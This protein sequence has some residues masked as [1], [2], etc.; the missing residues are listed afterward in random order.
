MQGNKQPLIFC[1]DAWCLYWKDHL[2]TRKSIYLNVLG[3]CESGERI[4]L[5]PE[6][7]ERLRQEQRIWKPEDQPK[8][9]PFPP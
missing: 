7:L 8:T 4:S 5:P 2:C 6:E 1:E 9:S 3:V